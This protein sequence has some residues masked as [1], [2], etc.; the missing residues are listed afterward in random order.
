VRINVDEID[1]RS[2]DRNYRAFHGFRQTKFA[3]GGL[4]FWLKPITLLPLLP[5]K[6]TLNLKVVKIEEIYLTIKLI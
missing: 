6:K 5:V 3:Y 4:F 1:A 2:H